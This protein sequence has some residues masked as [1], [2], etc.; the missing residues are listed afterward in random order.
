MKKKMKTKKS[1][2][3]WGH[4]VGTGENNKGLR[5]SHTMGIKEDFPLKYEKLIYVDFRWP[6]KGKLEYC[7]ILT[8]KYNLL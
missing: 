1:V 6:L 3:V 5:S 7:Y 8:L 4:G 2:T